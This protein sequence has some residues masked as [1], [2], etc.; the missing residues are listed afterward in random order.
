MTNTS[1][2]TAL[3]TGASKGLGRA[4]AQA[5]SDRGW[6]LVLDARSPG[7][8]AAELPGATVLAGDVSRVDENMPTAFQQLA[9]ESKAESARSTG[10]QGN[11]LRSRC[12]ALHACS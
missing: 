7:P 2:P 9:G 10:D 6:R 11:G 1:Q 8:L 12:H 5:L 4:V 3:I